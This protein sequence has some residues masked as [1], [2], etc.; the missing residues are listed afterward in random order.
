MIS[1]YTSITT[2][3]VL[4]SCCIH[5]SVSK[6]QRQHAYDC[7]STKPIPTGVYNHQVNRSS[8]RNDQNIAMNVNPTYSDLTNN[9]YNNVNVDEDTGLD[10]A[11]VE[12]RSR[13]I[14]TD[15]ITMVGNPAYAE[16]KFT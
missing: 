13:H 4:L 12:P 2:I 10:Y 5:C 1:I 9:T 7:V 3:Y 11:V 16:T 14:K 15:G 8:S 6:Q